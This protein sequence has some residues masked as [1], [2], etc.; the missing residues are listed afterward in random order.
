MDDRDIAPPSHAD[1]VRDFQRRPLELFL[2][3]YVADLRNRAVA[4]GLSSEHRLSD[5]SLTVWGDGSGIV[6][7]GGHQCGEFSTPIADAIREAEAFL[8]RDEKAEANIAIGLTAD[9]RYSEGDA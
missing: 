1:A 8:L 7:I 9:G 5:V 6:T 4:A 3:N 2:G